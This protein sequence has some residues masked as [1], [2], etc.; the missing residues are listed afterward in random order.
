MHGKRHA[1]SVCRVH[2]WRLR[3]HAVES[4]VIDVNASAHR[5]T[6]ESRDL[7][8]E[9]RSVGTVRFSQRRVGAFPLDLQVTLM[10]PRYEGKQS[11]NE[12]RCVDVAP[13]E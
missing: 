2:Q 6:G 4:D 11:T 7:S 1:L 9:S 3:K 5:D 8:M 12:V 10:A 13:H